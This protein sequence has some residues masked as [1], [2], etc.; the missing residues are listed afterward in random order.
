MCYTHTR[1]SCPS[2]IVSPFGHFLASPCPV[3]WRNDIDMISC[4]MYHVGKGVGPMISVRARMTIFSTCELLWDMHE[5]IAYF[6]YMDQLHVLNATARSSVN[7]AGWAHC[8]K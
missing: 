8:Q 2:R 3:S 1:A 5:R 4:Y 7:E 6:M